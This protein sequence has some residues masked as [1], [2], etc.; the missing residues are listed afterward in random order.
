MDLILIVKRRE[1]LYERSIAEIGKLFNTTPLRKNWDSI[2]S[3]IHLHSQQDSRCFIFSPSLSYNLYH[4][5]HLKKFRF[6]TILIRFKY[7]K[8]N[9]EKAMAEILAALRSLMS[10]HDPPLHALVVPSE[11][12]HQVIFLRSQFLFI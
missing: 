10:S 7:I 12:Y 4:I 6:I 5:N 1:Y 9:S 3:S 11:D 8:E 2:F